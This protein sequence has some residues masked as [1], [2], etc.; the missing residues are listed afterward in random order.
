MIITCTKDACQLKT[1][2]TTLE[3][4]LRA[5]DVDA[6]RYAINDI[7]LPG[8]GEYEVGEIFAEITPALAHFHLE[9]IVLVVRLD[10]EGTVTAAD[11]EKLERVDAFLLS[12][13][14]NEWSDLEASLKMSSK[15][16]PKAIILAGVDDP[17]T[18]AKLESR[19]PQSVESLKVT[20][21]DLPEEGQKFYV[22]K[23]R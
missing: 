21:K 1:K 11:F 12:A 20:A 10:D 9:D 22:M 17:D 18:L 15:M 14:S 8:P 2:N 19:S 4:Q 16:E 7:V 5:K 23:P 13:K 3:I 6:S